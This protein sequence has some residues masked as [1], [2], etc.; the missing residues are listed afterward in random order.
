LKSGVARVL[1]PQLAKADQRF[2]QFNSRAA[3]RLGFATHSSLK[4]AV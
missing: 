3:I 2:N 1:G 4:I